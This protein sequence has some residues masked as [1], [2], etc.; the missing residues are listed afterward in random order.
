M[1]PAPL[2]VTYL[3]FPTSGAPFFD[4]AITDRTIT[5][6]ILT[7]TT[8]NISSSLIIHTNVTIINKKYHI[9]LVEEIKILIYIMSFNNPIKLERSFFEI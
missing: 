8:K 6:K 4:Y 2:Q 9:E 3:G 5:P 7:N 1:R